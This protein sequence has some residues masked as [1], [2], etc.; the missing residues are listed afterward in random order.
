[1][2]YEE[3]CN[4]FRT[5]P[6][7]RVTCG[8][9]RNVGGDPNS[10]FSYRNG[11]ITIRINWSPTL[12]RYDAK[13][14]I[15]SQSEAPK[16][17]IIWR[18]I[19]KLGEYVNPNDPANANRWVCAKIINRDS[20]RKIATTYVDTLPSVEDEET[21]VTY[22]DILKCRRALY[23]KVEYIDEYM[24]GFTCPL[25][26]YADGRSVVALSTCRQV[27][28]NKPYN[29]CESVWKFT[30]PVELDSKTGEYNK[31]IP[32]VR[33]VVDPL[34]RRKTF[35]GN[36]EYISKQKVVWAIRADG[37]IFCLDYYTGKRIN[38]VQ[39]KGAGGNP[40]F[41]V[42][43][44]PVTCELLYTANRKV[45]S[46][47]VTKNG[48]LKNEELKGIDGKNGGQILDAW[49]DVPGNRY[50]TA[51]TGAVCTVSPSNQA[52][53]RF[54]I[55]YKNERV[56]IVPI[57]CSSG[58]SRIAERTIGNIDR[59]HFGCSDKTRKNQY[60]IYGIVNAID[61]A[62]WVNGHTPL[63]YCYNIKKTIN[64]Q[65]VKISGVCK[66]HYV[67]S[68]YSKSQ[69]RKK[70]QELLGFSD[71]D[72]KSKKYATANNI[73]A[74]AL[75]GNKVPMPDYALS[76]RA[77]D[78][79][80]HEKVYSDACVEQGLNVDDQLKNYRIM[81]N[82][83]QWGEIGCKFGLNSKGVGFG[84]NN[85]A[86]LGSSNK[87]HINKKVGYK[88]SSYMPK[89][90]QT[91]SGEIKKINESSDAPILQDIGFIYG[92]SLNDGF[93]KNSNSTFGCCQNY[94]FSN[95]Q[96]ESEIANNNYG[97]DYRPPIRTACKDGKDKQAAADKALSEFFHPFTTNDENR[98]GGWWGTCPKPNTSSGD[99]DPS[100][101]WVYKPYLDKN[102]SVPQASWDVP[103]SQLGIGVSLPDNGSLIGNKI[104]INGKIKDSY[105]IYQVNY[106]EN[107]LHKI[108]IDNGTNARSGTAP[109]LSA[110][111][112]GN[113]ELTL[114][115]FYWHQANVNTSGVSKPTHV[116]VDDFNCVWVIGVNSIYRFYPSELSAMK[117]PAAV[118]QTEISKDND[119]YLYDQGLYNNNNINAAYFM[120]GQHGGN[121]IDSEYAMIQMWSQSPNSKPQVMTFSDARA[122]SLSHPLYWYG[123]NDY[124]RPFHKLN[125]NNKWYYAL[126]DN[127]EAGGGGGTAGWSYCHRLRVVDFKIN[128]DDKVFGN[129][130]THVTYNEYNSDNLG[131]HALIAQGEVSMCEI[132][133]PA[134]RQPRATL[135]ITGGSHTNPNECD[136]LEYNCDSTEKMCIS[137]WGDIVYEDADQNILS[138]DVSLSSTVSLAVRGYDDLKTEHTI[139]Y[140]DIENYDVASAALFAA[141]SESHNEFLKY[142]TSVVE[143]NDATSGSYSLWLPDIIF[144]KDPNVLGGY[145]SLS[146]S[147]NDITQTSEKTVSGQLICKGNVYQ[148]AEYTNETVVPAENINSI[149]LFERWSEP[150]YCINGL[151]PGMYGYDDVLNDM[152][153]CE[154]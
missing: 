113:N 124:V 129:T 33:I 69:S 52:H 101:H 141:G 95:G 2:A 76:Y 17:V 88:F 44:N 147:R 131:I 51:A 119:G 14:K 35:I 26:V 74:S 89:I 144:W 28:A 12:N 48:I 130:D 62:V 1:M 37:R 84:G 112:S 118:Y 63:D 65:K 81:C 71:N 121:F 153:N 27:I 104:G 18:L 46:V 38:D 127:Y 108:L 6:T 146:A 126:Q 143:T 115:S 50:F 98:R 83:N 151:N 61:Q 77:S 145:I 21:I 78:N 36:G 109:L 29:D 102:K 128:G 87:Y 123:S 40:I 136:N 64:T 138:S 10:D 135:R 55:V 57:D 30:A 9:L 34:E 94:N 75:Q 20:Q 150:A 103:M 149:F 19:G 4:W 90:H 96:I 106:Q 39:A 53:V 56:A 16:R 111:P 100:D 67:N 107:T 105:Y 148:I 23:Y 43:L 93:T 152:W 125:D 133:H 114:G 132:T 41:A 137:G 91:I 86:E 139:E 66:K 134:Y 11:K 72:L 7:N 8:R 25:F 82:N 13:G 15:V 117:Y 45:Y 68:K 97:K 42:A 154:T 142:S 32:F 5:E 59:R 3:K 122:Y 70:A 99:K 54:Y 22:Y 31:Q 85:I 73:L 140:T 47:T 116:I 24:S 58:T 79:S 120:Y 80:Y 60:N 49:T 92:C 110:Q